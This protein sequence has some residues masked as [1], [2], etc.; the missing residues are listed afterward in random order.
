MDAAFGEKSLKKASFYFIMKKVKA[1]KTTN[2]LRHKNPKK[3][4]RTV[5]IVAAVTADIKEDRGL[6]CHEIASSQGVSYGTMN[7]ILHDN[8]GLVKKLARWVP[9]PLSED[10]KKERECELAQVIAA[11]NRCSMAML[12]NI[13]MMEETMVSPHTPVMKKKSK[14][15]IKKGWSDPIKARVHASRTKQM[16]L[17]LFDSKGLI[18]TIMHLGSTINANYIVK[19]LGKFLMH[20]K[21]KRPEMVQQEWFFHWDNAPGHTAA[22]VKK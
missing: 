17:A 14:Q 6:T 4:K 20:L 19:A 2:V 12:D 21:K 22:S 18:Y 11:V 15:W 10:Q 9:K 3:T 5:N 8:L 16:L 7:K 1:G 13:V